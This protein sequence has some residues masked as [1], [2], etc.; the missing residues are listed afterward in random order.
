MGCRRHACRWQTE[1][2]QST[3]KPVPADDGRAAELLFTGRSMSVEEG[4]AWGFYNRLSDTVLDDAQVDAAHVQRA[5]VWV[6]VELHG[7]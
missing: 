2:D 4:Q 5:V 7:T 3:S 1:T 6:Q